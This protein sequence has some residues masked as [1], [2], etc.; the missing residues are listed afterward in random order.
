M[1]WLVIV[2]N[3][4]PSTYT[5]YPTDPKR[6]ALYITS[7]GVW[8]RIRHPRL[9]S[10]CTPWGRCT[11]WVYY[12]WPPCGL[13]V[14]WADGLTDRFVGHEPIMSLS[15]TL[16]NGSVTLILLSH[17]VLST[18]GFGVDPSG[19]RVDSEGLQV[20]MWPVLGRVPVFFDL[21]SLALGCGPGRLTLR[22]PLRALG[23]WAYVI[24][25]NGGLGRTLRP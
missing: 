15:P 13:T 11:F 16:E 24:R 25:R 8:R 6:I 14:Q 23:S 12:I 5:A 2:M 21:A 18:L 10:P 19:R 3:P 7:R 1:W 22:S 9:F 20:C 17:L 4:I